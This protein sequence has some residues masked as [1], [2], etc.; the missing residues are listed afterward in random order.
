MVGGGVE[1]S[2]SSCHVALNAGALFGSLMRHG[3]GCSCLSAR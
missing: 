1:F 2:T 3:L